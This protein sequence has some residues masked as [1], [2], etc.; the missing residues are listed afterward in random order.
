LF[1][2]IDIKN[3]VSIWLTDQK[4]DGAEGEPRNERFV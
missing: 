4:T 1:S 3:C 2:A